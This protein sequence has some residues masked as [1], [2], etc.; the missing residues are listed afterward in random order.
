MRSE[1]RPS[2]ATLKWEIAGQWGPPEPHTQSQH[3]KVMTIT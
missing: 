3:V 1:A 2:Q